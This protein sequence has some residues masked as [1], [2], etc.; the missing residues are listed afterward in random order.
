[1]DTID[2]NK[3][4]KYLIPDKYLYINFTDSYLSLML[5]IL[6]IVLIFMTIQKINYDYN[7]INLLKMPFNE[8]LFYNNVIK[9]LKELKN[10]K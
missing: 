9:E 1:M 10:K 4:N 2:K 6:G 7:V 8:I 5:S 3:K